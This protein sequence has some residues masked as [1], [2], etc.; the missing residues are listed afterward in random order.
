MSGSGW[1]RMLLTTIGLQLGV[2]VVAGL[3]VA[4]FDARAAMSLLLGGMAVVVPNALLAFYLWSKARIIRALSAATFMA[5]ES[6]KLGA[7][8]ALL[9][10]AT[11]VLGPAAVWPALVAGVFLALKGQWLAVWFTRDS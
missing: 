8:V 5:G 6:L 7:T 11:R 2:V 4:L 1:A 9:F 10:I 3:G